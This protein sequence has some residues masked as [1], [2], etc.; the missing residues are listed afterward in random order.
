MTMHRFAELFAGVAVLLW[1]SRF[2]FDLLRDRLHNRHSKQ[3]N[4]GKRENNLDVCVPLIA[5]QPYPV[6]PDRTKSPGYAY[7]G[8]VCDSRSAAGTTGGFENDLQQSG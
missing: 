1:C 6:S 4:G 8:R 3:N 7:E 5:L 2:V